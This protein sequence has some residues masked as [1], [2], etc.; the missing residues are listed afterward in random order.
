MNVK[1]YRIKYYLNGK[2]VEESIEDYND[3][4]TDEDVEQSALHFAQETIDVE[5]ERVE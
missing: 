2:L 4:C 3:D 5:V 1:M